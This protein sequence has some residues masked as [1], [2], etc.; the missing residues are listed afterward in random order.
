MEARETPQVRVDTLGNKGIIE[1]QYKV[2]WV[3]R[4]ISQVHL[5]SLRY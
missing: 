5:D 2:K 1:G 4:Y 3:K